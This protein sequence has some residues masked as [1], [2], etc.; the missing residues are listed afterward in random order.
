M[1]AI[2]PGQK[3]LTRGIFLIFIFPKK[4]WLAL[5]TRYNG[6]HCLIRCHKNLQT[7]D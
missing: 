7:G 5:I 2:I 4:K 6:L 1:K 3:N